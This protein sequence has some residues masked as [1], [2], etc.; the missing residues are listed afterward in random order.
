MCPI[1]TVNNRPARKT[2]KISFRPINDLDLNK[3]SEWLENQDWGPILNEKSTNKKAE[4]LQNILL[5]KF[6]EY[7]P[8]KKKVISSDDQPFVTQ[9][10]KSLKR[11]KGREYHKHRK[12]QK[13]VDLEEKYQ[14]EFT[15]AKSTYYKK[16]IKKC[17][18]LNPKMV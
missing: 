12:S 13:W 15:E 1:S 10:L 8:E 2:K 5:V 7:F 18:K 6:N 16:K 9:K 11:R 14:K 4:S 17:M 3:M